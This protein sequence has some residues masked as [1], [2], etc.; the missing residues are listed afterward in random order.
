LS[1]SGEQIFHPSTDNVVRTYTI[2]SNANVPYGIGTLLNFVNRSAASLQIAINSD[3][4]ILAGSTTTGTRTLSQ[5][6]S[7]TALKI[8]T[9]VWLIG[10][11]T[12]T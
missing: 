4:L 5:N 10:G 11:T 6:G 7:A 8:E 9:T 12:L 3:T 1:D 2:D